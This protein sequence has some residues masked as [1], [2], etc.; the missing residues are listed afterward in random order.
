MPDS[1]TLVW[2]FVLVT[3]LPGLGLLMADRLPS[4]A[5]SGLLLACSGAWLAMACLVVATAA[6]NYGLG[7]LSS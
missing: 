7:S 2:I 5:R 1:S 3:L 4:Q 6:M